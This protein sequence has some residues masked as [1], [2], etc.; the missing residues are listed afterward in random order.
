MLSSENA[1]AY[2]NMQQEAHYSAIKSRH[3]FLQFKKQ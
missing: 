3:E 1:V 2:P